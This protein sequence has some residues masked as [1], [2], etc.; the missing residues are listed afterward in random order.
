MFTS[1]TTDTRGPYF[2]IKLIQGKNLPIRDYTGFS[3][4]Y[5]IF[6]AGSSQIRSSVKIKN[7]NPVWNEDLKL[8]VNY[9][10]LQENGNMIIECWDLDYLKRDDYMG[11][12]LFSL[13]DLKE[14]ET[15]KKIV[16]LQDVES[17]TLEFEITGF[18]L[19][20]DNSTEF[21]DE[22]KKPK[23]P[24]EVALFKLQKSAAYKNQKPEHLAIFGDI[25][26]SKEKLKDKYLSTDWA[27]TIEQQQFLRKTLSSVP[28]LDIEAFE[29]KLDKFEID[30]IMKNDFFDEDD[31][32]KELES[33]VKIKLVLIDQHMNS[34]IQ[35]S[36][37]KF[38]SPIA[39][40]FKLSPLGIFHTAL[41]IGPWLIDWNDSALC[42]PRKCVSRAAF[43]SI[44]LDT[45]QTLEGLEI[46][47][48]KVA[49]SVA[50]WNGTK[51]YSAFPGKKH[52][53]NCQEFVENVINEIGVKID[54]DGAI[55]AYMNKIKQTGK[56][57]LEFIIKKKFQKKFFLDKTSYT[58]HTHEELDKF[59]A[60][61]IDV[62]PSLEVN[63]PT[64]WELL[65]GFDRAFW[66]RHKKCE[67]EKK[68]LEEKALKYSLLL[69]DLKKED[70]ERVQERIDEIKEAIQDIEFS[71]TKISP[72]KSVEKSIQVE[73]CPFENPSKTKS[74]WVSQKGINL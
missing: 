53:G 18:D 23:S 32:E 30:E 21:K 42:I 51:F 26:T 69:E 14:G 73:C 72:M 68:E 67:G 44:N 70:Q 58:F 48:D 60:H 33:E 41:M 25:L 52:A 9:Q 36:L 24:A 35:Q 63:H 65:K 22:E 46:V 56:L 45:I 74:F 15:V 55:A 37:R 19:D 59:V 34:D 38:L 2:L 54:L 12:V 64:H 43:V 62:D 10:H 6:I 13:S 27:A 40:E 11:Q 3:D 28:D 20:Y 16:K 49:N 66:M 17:G 31:M 39:N 57:R 71:Q 61:L 29:R 5:V 47:V 7:L 8:T 4:P 50:K 1:S